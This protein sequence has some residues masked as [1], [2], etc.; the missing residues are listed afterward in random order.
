MSI[1]LGDA[2]AHAQQS[3]AELSL[4]VVRSEPV[5]LVGPLLHRLPTPRGVL[6]W[7]RDGEGLIGWGE[8]ARLEV[9]GPDRVEVA[10]RWWRELVA[11]LAVED[12][13][14][15]RGTGPVLFGSFAFTAD[16]PSVL[17]LPEV[18]LGPGWRRSG[19]PRGC[20][21]LPRC[22]PRGT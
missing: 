12:E 11:G 10:Q 20:P 18:V 8:A 15:A 17:V 19:S 1:G 13:V 22:R 16:E 6:A 14:G 4:P 7:V 21:P 3:L 2:R 5:D 9:S